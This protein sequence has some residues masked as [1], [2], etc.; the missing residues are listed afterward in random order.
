MAGHLALGGGGG[1]LGSGSG[2]S[3]GGGQRGGD[4][5]GV[6]IFTCSALLST[7]GAMASYYDFD[8]GTES[9]FFA[10]TGLGA[11]CFAKC[12]Y[13]RLAREKK[14]MRTKHHEGPPGWGSGPPPEET[15]ASY[16]HGPP[17]GEFYG[18][19]PPHHHRYGPPHQTESQ[20]EETGKSSHLGEERHQEDPQIWKRTGQF[21][22]NNDSEVNRS[23]P[24]MTPI[25]VI[26]Q[27][28]KEQLNDPGVTK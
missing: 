25:E 15:I 10:V 22:D 17:P 23:G 4:G 24:I 8:I 18:P 3:L 21:S 13:L 12:Q 14:L 9:A 7:L 6:C 20:E 5:G 26:T 11:L 16:A 1:G 19:P 28:L 27:H 2:L